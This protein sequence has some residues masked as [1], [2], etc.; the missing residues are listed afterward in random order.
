MKNIY[1]TQKLKLQ[2]GN[3][4]FETYDIGNNSK[5]IP[6][7][8][9][10]IGI[11]NIHSSESLSNIIDILSNN[12]LNLFYQ[13][14]STNFKRNIDNLN[15]KFYFET[16][17]ILSSNNYD[18]NNLFLIL[19]KQIS[20]Y[21]KEIER[22]NAIILGMKKDEQSQ[23]KL[24]S[25]LQ[26]REMDFETKDN[27]IKTLQNSNNTLEKKISN[28]IL[29]E[30]N[31]KQENIRLVKENMFYKNNNSNS[32]LC[33]NNNSNEKKR[34][35]FF[36]EKIKKNGLINC[37]YKKNNLKYNFN[38]KISSVYSVNN[39]KANNSNNNS[40]SKN[41]KKINKENIK[42]N[43]N[44]ENDSKSI[45]I[46]V[47]RDEHLLLKRHRRNYSDQI[48]IGVLN[49]ENVKN[50]YKKENNQKNTIKNKYQL[51]NSNKNDIIPLGSTTHKGNLVQ[52]RNNHLNKVNIKQKSQL[53]NN[54]SIKNIHTSKKVI[55][56]KKTDLMANN[57]NHIDLV[58]NIDKDCSMTKYSSSV[59]NKSNIYSQGN[60]NISINLTENNYDFFIENEIEDLSLLENLLNQV[61]DYIKGNILGNNKNTNSTPDIIKI[62]C[63]NYSNKKEIFNVN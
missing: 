39:T 20:L 48:G 38:N 51:K 3:Q 40:I 14:D 52:L 19:F 59:F 5:I 49:Q 41:D 33:N 13:D 63:H 36:N 6:H 61:K 62:N 54:K 2:N 16:E 45:I 27:I 22:L 4:N 15:L 44:S 7:C 24:S 10:E 46:S 1:E 55:T 26:R 8:E 25:F 56:K 9:T 12:N 34:V 18:S 60:G 42:I 35:Y 32:K 23:E 30:S 31:L 21:I 58:S 57:K 28:L 53:A 37:K 29:S 43:N 47:K 17:N 11:E 50:L